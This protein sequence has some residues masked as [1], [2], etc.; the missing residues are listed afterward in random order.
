[1]NKLLFI[2]I[3]SIFITFIIISP[4]KVIAEE[5][6]Y[7]IGV[8]DVLEVTMTWG[9]QTISHTATVPPDGKISLPMINDIQ[10]KGLSPIQLKEG[11]MQRLNKIV[12]N[13]DVTV[14]VKGING[15]TIIISND[16]KG[17][18]H[19]HSL[20]EEEIKEKIVA[21]NTLPPSSTV[22]IEEDEY[23]IGA[24]DVLN[25]VIWGNDAL[26]KEVR[27]RPDGKI[28]L[29]L[30]NDLQAEGLS[31]I[32]LSDSITNRLKEFVDAPDVTVIVRE[33][34]SFKISITGEVVR[35]GVIK[36]QSKTTIIEA[37]SLTGGVTAW[38]SPNRITVVRKD[39][40]G[41]K[42][43]LV[44]Y[45]DILKGKDPEGNIL[46]KP[47]DTIIVPRSLF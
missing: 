16:S 45:N 24:E 9:N 26:S 38:A 15:K 36:L 13:P 42:R 27:V 47:G 37:I 43:I 22:T 29:P 19:E 33:I 32:Q 3:T 2:F 20:R 40:N 12:Y 41:E 44:R 28:S 6:E 7:M 30:I 18:S 35:P 5:E 14:I 23:T 8:K 34:N 11:I 25:I 4:S 1:M 31:P 21:P 17:S 46:L 39:K 10:A